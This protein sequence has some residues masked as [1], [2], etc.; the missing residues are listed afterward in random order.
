VLLHISTL[1][2]FSKENDA[3]DDDEQADQKHENGYAVDAVH[4]FH[5]FAMRG[6]GVALFDVKVF[7]DLP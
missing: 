4:V 3:N 5:P 2:P 7:G 6:I 1:M